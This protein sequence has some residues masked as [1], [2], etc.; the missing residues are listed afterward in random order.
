M[1][2]EKKVIQSNRQFLQI[3]LKKNNSK[4]KYTVH[5]EKSDTIR[6]AIMDSFSSLDRRKMGE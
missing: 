1:Q 6:L 2:N 4:E 3:Q 5:K